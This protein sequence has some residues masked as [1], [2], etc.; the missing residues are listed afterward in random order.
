MT[1]W[2]V[3]TEAG[4]DEE[5]PLCVADTVQELRPAEAGEGSGGA[6]GV[7]VFGGAEWLGVHLGIGFCALR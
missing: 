7:D 1:G 6:E 4:S 3:L 2:T 5:L